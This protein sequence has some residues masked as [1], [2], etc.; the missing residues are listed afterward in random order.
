MP[1][2]IPKVRYN[3]PHIYLTKGTAEIQYTLFLYIPLLAGTKVVLSSDPDALLVLCTIV[4][5]TNTPDADFFYTRLPFNLPTLT[6]VNAWAK[7]YII[8]EDPSI[9][10]Q[11]DNKAT[12]ANPDAKPKYKLAISLKDTDK[13]DA[14]T[15]PVAYNCPHIYLTNPNEEILDPTPNSPDFA[16]RCFIPLS[17]MSYNSADQPGSNTASIPGNCLQR[18]ELYDNPAS[19]QTKVDP[20]HIHANNITYLDNNLIVGYFEVTVAHNATADPAPTAPVK[21]GKLRNRSSDTHPS[22]L[23]RL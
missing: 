20:D 18:V 12:V 1:V 14:P 11:I 22:G 15:G 23:I 6:L 10:I 21:K 4:D 13:K 9:S 5:G 3:A 19:T 17:G 2:A 16:P 8:E 7:E